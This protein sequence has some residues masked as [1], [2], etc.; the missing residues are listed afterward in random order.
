MTDEVFDYSISPEI[1]A[2][3]NS[4]M[5]VDTK[6]VATP[7]NKVADIAT[8]GS[9]N[10]RFGLVLSIAVVPELDK[11]E[12]PIMVSQTMPTIFLDADTLEDLKD[13]VHEEIDIIIRHTDDV[14]SG[15]IVPPT[16]EDFDGQ[17]SSSE[18]DLKLH[19]S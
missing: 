16:A 5:M 14:I 4:Y 3:T 15:R 12:D 2:K 18:S 9:R 13:R 19:T 17:S 11:Q 10:R 8:G 7:L 6:F 1:D